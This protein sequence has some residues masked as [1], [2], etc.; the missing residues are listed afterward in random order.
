MGGELGGGG[1]KS[2]EESEM[3]KWKIYGSLSNGRLRD[4]RAWATIVPGQ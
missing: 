4:S 2:C 1:G 3:P